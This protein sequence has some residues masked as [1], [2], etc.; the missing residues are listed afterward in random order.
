MSIKKQTS[1]TY[2]R[3]A[4]AVAP[5]RRHPFSD[6]SSPGTKRVGPKNSDAIDVRE[7]HS[8][9]QTKKGS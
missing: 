8:V 9:P 1:P 5:E 7:E 4:P 2:P 6:T 3:Y